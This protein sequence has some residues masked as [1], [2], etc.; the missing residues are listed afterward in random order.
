MLSNL[1]ISEICDDYYSALLHQSQTPYSAPNLNSNQKSLTNITTPVKMNKIHKLSKTYQNIPHKNYNN[2]NY[3]NS[4]VECI[5]DA[6]YNIQTN[7]IKYKI[8]EDISSLNKNDENLELI[9]NLSTPSN[10]IS[11]NKIKL[12]NSLNKFLKDIYIVIDGNTT[13]IKEEIFENKEKFLKIIAHKFNDNIVNCSPFTKSNIDIH[14]VFDKNALNH[15]MNKNI[16]VNYS[17]T[18]LKNKVKFEKI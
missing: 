17:F 1:L 18:T 16:F 4:F 14:I 11:I 15:I 9:L 10:V 8:F 2:F 5:D 6:N 3:T 12:T 7:E 13:M